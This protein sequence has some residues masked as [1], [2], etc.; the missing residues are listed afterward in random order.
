MLM[1]EMESMEKRA[2]IR[3]HIGNKKRPILYTKVRMRKEW[4]N[5]DHLILVPKGG[6]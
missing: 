6:D 4:Q 5:R 1:D 2:K 3:T